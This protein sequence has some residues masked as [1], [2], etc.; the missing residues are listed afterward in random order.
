L[1]DILPHKFP[2]CDKD[3]FYPLSKDNRIPKNTTFVPQ[4]FLYMINWKL[5]I[6]L[7]AFSLSLGAQNTSNPFELTPRLAEDDQEQPSASTTEDTALVSNPFELKERQTEQAT[8]NPKTSN[9]NPFDLIVETPKPTTISVPSPREPSTSS[10]SEEHTISKL[11]LSKNNGV[12]LSIT[13][14]VLTFTSISL[15]FF[16]SL[17]AKAYRSLFNDNLL[18]LLYREREAGSLGSFLIAYLVFFLGGALF[19]CLLS[20]HY[21]WVNSSNLWQQY[22]FFLATLMGVFIGKHLLLAL[23]G[24]VFPIRKEIKRYS[25]TIMIFS[26]V[27]GLLLTLGSVLLAYTPDRLHIFVIYSLLG[28]VVIIYALRSLRGLFIANRFI[29]NYQFHF[30]SYICAVEIGPVLCLYKLVVDF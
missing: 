17:Y 3:L 21:G 16:R 14:L 4:L 15:I 10:L 28:M 8:T 18:S 22:G 30:L 19:L 13:L 11:P 5:A 9:G 27:L 20:Q 24:Y 29:F 2:T 12:L 6:I 23:L 7:L 1:R 25:F 26:I